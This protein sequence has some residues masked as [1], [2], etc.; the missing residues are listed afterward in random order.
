MVVLEPD[1]CTACGLCVRICHQHCIHLNGG[2]V[3]IG[4][5]LCSTCTQCIAVCPERAL[6]WNHQAPERF[7]KFQLP[8]PRQLVELLRERRTIRFFAAEK[9][10]RNLIEEIVAMGVFAPTNNYAMRAIVVDDRAQ[11]GELDRL[12]MKFVKRVYKILYCP[13]TIFALLRRLT[14]AFTP[15]D[16]A[17]MEHDISA[18]ST[19]R[20]AAATV[21]IVGDRRIAL[22]QDSAQYA[23]YN[24]ILYAHL[25]GI[26]TRL[27]GPG[28]IMLDRSAAARRML[29]LGKH[30]SWACW[31]WVSRDRVCEQGKREVAAGA[32]GATLG[33]NR[34]RPVNY[35]QHKNN[36]G[37]NPFSIPSRSV[38]LLV[39]LLRNE[40]VSGVTALFQLKRAG[41]CSGGAPLALPSIA[42]R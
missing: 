23:L 18:G 34:V 8:S 17:K 4:P 13:K 3:V 1:R 19:T 5:E 31:K 28:P 29:G 36:F 40:R 27:R 7:D 41:T 6:S 42:L 24:M 35:D 2:G 14:S 33:A 20:N 22:S 32:L 21:F 10:E 37:R 39:G 38:T 30:E 11:I 12:V 25:P 16:K 9:M 26:G 15:T